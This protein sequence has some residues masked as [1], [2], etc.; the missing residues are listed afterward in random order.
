M[1]RFIHS[2]D[3]QLGARFAQFGA[4]GT[5][6]REVRLSTLQR[7]LEVAQQREVDAF[8]VAGDLFEDNQVDD[9][10]V[11][12]VVQIFSKYPSVPIYLLPGNHDPFSGPESVWMRRQFIDAPKHI[13]I[14]SQAGV[15]ELDGV[16]L[17]SSPLQQKMST[18]DP[19]MKLVELAATIPESAIKIGV[20]HGAL[21]IEG[22]HQPNDFP[23]ALNAASRAGLDYLA[24]GHWHNW[25]DDMDGARIVMPGTPEPDRFDHLRCGFIAYVEIDSPGADPRIEP[26]SVASLT[27][28][29]L[30]FDFLSAES[31]RATLGQTLTDLASAGGK[32]VVR[33]VLTGAASPS[34]ILE[35]HAWL[36]RLLE[37]FLVALISDRSSVAL[38]SAELQDLQMRHPIL[39]QVLA[40]IDQ[41]ELL[42][43]GR[44]S[45]T[46]IAAT[47]PLTLTEAQTLLASAKIDL[48]SLTAEQ[49]TQTRQLL[50]Q[51]MQ[52]AAS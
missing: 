13:R 24:I 27:W 17:I 41:I 14:L 10:L 34:Q 43:T 50:L 18:L 38:S 40:D 20:T 44:G 25:L 1:F 8:I 21:A 32:T 39:A 29:E 47:G 33:V 49:L 16:F 30:T 37:P 9:D 26:V 52:Q 28:K 4:K 31:S 45:G 15:T 11:L 42:A 7:A 6:L 46:T 23:I 12:A 3:W 22:K 5:T 2:A 51:T 19:S 36:N 35:V 48:T